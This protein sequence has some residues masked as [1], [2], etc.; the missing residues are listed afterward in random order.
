MFC[1]LQLTWRVV[2]FIENTIIPI[3]LLDLLEFE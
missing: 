3:V 2:N 1:F